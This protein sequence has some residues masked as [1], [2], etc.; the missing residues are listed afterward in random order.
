MISHCHQYATLFCFK[1]DTN[2]TKLWSTLHIGGKEVISNNYLN[3][4]TISIYK[5]IHFPKYTFKKFKN[6]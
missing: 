2:E 3:L 6:T 5:L 1:L 4:I